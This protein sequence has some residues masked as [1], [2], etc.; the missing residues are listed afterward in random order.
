[1]KSLKISILLI[2]AWIAVQAQGPG[3]DPPKPVEKVLGFSLGYRSRQLVDEQKSALT[4]TSRETLPGIFYRR[5]GPASLFKLSVRAGTGDFYGQHFRNRWLYTT[6]YDLQGIPAKDSTAVRSV[7]TGG[8]V[9]AD[10]LLKLNPGKRTTW[11]AGASIKEMMVYTDNKI[12]LLNSLGLH[13]NLG[14]IHEISAKSKLRVNFSVPLAALNSRLP[15]HNTASDPIDSE[16]WTFFKK[17]TRLVGPDDFRMPELDMDY[18]LRICRGWNIGAGYSFTWL[19]IPAYQP[20]KSVLHTFQIQT[21]FK[22]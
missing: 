19:H 17:G 15:W 22:L 8:N 14:V 21:S 9:E 10:F 11:L 20:L 4:Y 3:T 13:A 18:E 6:T 12:G 5:E 7:L 16:T 2:C 1:M